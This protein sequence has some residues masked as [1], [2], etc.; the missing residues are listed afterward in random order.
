M[1]EIIV[2]NFK[3]NGLASC[4]DFVFN[5]VSSKSAVNFEISLGRE[6]LRFS[7]SGKRFLSLLIILQR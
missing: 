6:N 5:F 7:L 1:I 4:G 3:M 2:P